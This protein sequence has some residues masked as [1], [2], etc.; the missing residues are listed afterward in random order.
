M[1]YKNSEGQKVTTWTL[2]FKLYL[3]FRRRLGY[4]LKRESTGLFFD[5]LLKTLEGTQLSDR[6]G[7]L[8]RTKKS[9]HW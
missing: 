6:E 1:E 2:G 5:V 4:S 9:G 7:S 3:L 8:P